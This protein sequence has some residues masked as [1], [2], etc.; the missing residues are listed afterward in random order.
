MNMSNDYKG[1]N[2]K[3]ED[4]NFMDLKGN[5][6]QNNKKNNSLGTPNCKLIFFELIFNFSQ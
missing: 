5:K 1:G 4:A 6:P 3:P 2:M